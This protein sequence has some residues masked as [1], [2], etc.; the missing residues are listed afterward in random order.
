MKRKSGRSV[1]LHWNYGSIFTELKMI[2]SGWQAN[3]VLNDDDL[4]LEV[5]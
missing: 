4:G 3:G 5:F 1:T 2:G